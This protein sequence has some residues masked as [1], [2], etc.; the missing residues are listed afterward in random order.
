MLKA[1]ILAAGRGT[2][3]RPHTDNKP[4]CL[5]EIDGKT[6]LE[7]QIECLNELRID[8][9]SIVGGYC[10]DTIR[11]AN[12]EIDLL[13]NHEFEESN[14]VWSLLSAGPA[15]SG[16]LIVTYGD[17]AYSRRSLT[18][19]VECTD[20]VALAIDL[21]WESY[22]RARFNNPL[23]DAETLRL[24]E[25]NYI[26]EIG[27]KPESLFEIEG[28][29]TGLIKFSQKGID[30]VFELL[31]S[32]EADQEVSGKSLKTAFMTD[33]LQ[34]MIT[35][36]FKVKAV[37]INGGWIEIDTERDL[38]SSFTRSRLRHFD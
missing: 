27:G 21:D 28:Q 2:R 22:W 10:A 13:I 32:C 30:Q 23:D 17:I 29:Y 37:P 3:L 9:I 15:F 16:D 25:N 11:A 1:L 20:D 24:D 26:T 6:L 4:K 5:L 35:Q 14:M 8:H 36:G 18:A 34:E 12:P 38:T 19:L 31:G 33:L 7:R